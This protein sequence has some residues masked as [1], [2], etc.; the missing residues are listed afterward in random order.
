MNRR[1]R[2]NAPAVAAELIDGEAVIMNLTT[3]SY[4]SARGTG[5]MIWEWVEQGIPEASIA[6]ALSGA[7]DGADAADVAQEVE[8]FLG[9]LLT[10]A[11]VREIPLIGPIPPPDAVTTTPGSPFVPPTLDVFN[12]MQDLLL[13]DPIHDVQEE[14]GWPAPKPPE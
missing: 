6:A 5:A 3:G 13:L 2:I 11:L 8:R 12:D 9:E 10:H 4:F 14:A 7:S 1:F